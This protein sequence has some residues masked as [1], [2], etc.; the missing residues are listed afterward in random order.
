MSYFPQFYRA[1]QQAVPQKVLRERSEETVV[2][3]KSG[4]RESVAARFDE[5]VSFG[6]DSGNVTDVE[7]ASESFAAYDEEGAD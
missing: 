1:S 2:T 5:S 7:Q 3:E 6:D 4:D